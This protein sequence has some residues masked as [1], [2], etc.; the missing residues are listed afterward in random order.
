MLKLPKFDFVMPHTALSI[1]GL[2]RDSADETFLFFLKLIKYV[3]TWR[4]HGGL[5]WNWNMCTCTPSDNR[6]GEANYYYISSKIMLKN[7]TPISKL[8]FSRVTPIRYSSFRIVIFFYYF[9][10]FFLVSGYKV[11]MVSDLSLQ[12]QGGTYFIRSF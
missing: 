12:S 8:I 4:A 9:L 5:V 11:I 6:H 1:R 2:L 3:F 7:V 10:L